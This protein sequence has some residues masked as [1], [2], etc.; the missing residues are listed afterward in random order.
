M[1]NLKRYLGYYDNYGSENEVIFYILTNS[2]DEEYGAWDVNIETLENLFPDTFDRNMTIFST[3]N[4]S[5]NALTDFGFNNIIDLTEYYS[6]NKLYIYFTNTS[7]IIAYTKGSSNPLV[8]EYYLNGIKIGNL[9]QPLSLNANSNEKYGSWGFVSYSG[10]IGRVFYSLLS[11]A[12]GA[13]DFWGNLTPI[14]DTFTLNSV[15]LTFARFPS[16]ALP[17]ATTISAEGTD[18][19]SITS[20]L[21][22]G[23]QIWQPDDEVAKENTSYR[24]TFPVTINDTENY[25]WAVAGTVIAQTSV[26]SVSVESTAWVK[27]TDALVTLQVVFGETGTTQDP[28]NPGGTSG[29]GGGNGEFDGTSDTVGFPDVIDTTKIGSIFGAM[30][31]VYLPTIAQFRT[32]C[33]YLWG[34]SIWRAISTLTDGY[35]TDI[36]SQALLSHHL[37]PL[38]LMSL[39]TVQVRIGWIEPEGI[40]MNPAAE[41]YHDL[42]CGSVT[43]E[44]YWNGYMDFHPYTQIRMYL[45]Y[46]GFIP[47]NADEVMGLSITVKYRVCVANGDF[48]CMVAAGGNVIST[49]SGNCSMQLPLTGL[50]DINAQLRA[51]GLLSIVSGSV[52]GGLSGALG[53]AVTSVAENVIG[54]KTFTQVIGDMRGNS[55]FLANQKPYVIIHRPRQLVPERQHKYTGYPSFVTMTLGSCIG[56]TQVEDI[57]LDGIHATADEMQEIISLL[58]SGV[59]I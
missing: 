52:S 42:S 27:V 13:F 47:V 56:F 3:S 16:P 9:G 22:V 35:P 41:E 34:S 29:T 24:V 11:I 23:S 40:E 43:I 55:G 10:S 8:C 51:Q 38:N 59:I 33:G 25:L 17:L 26:A 53:S 58:K 12:G 6:S 4:A 32:F 21:T 15:T 2:N 5:V 31:T 48:S 49:H 57:N 50:K 37:I 1:A 14:P 30:G 28:Y 45:P 46:V 44:P 36:L 54:Q 39:A 7:Y 19:S 18:G 20:D